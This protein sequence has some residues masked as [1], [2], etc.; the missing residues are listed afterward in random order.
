MDSYVRDCLEI[1]AAL[2]STQIPP[3]RTEIPSALGVY[4]EEGWKALDETRQQSLTEFASTIAS[5]L[6][7]DSQV[8]AMQLLDDLP[9]L[10]NAALRSPLPN[11]YVL[12]HH[13][14]R[15]ANIAWH[16]DHGARL[17]DWSWADIGRPGSDAT[18]LLID[19]HKH[20][21]DITPYLAKVNRE[22]CVAL[23]G[24]WLEHALRPVGE[25]DPSIR[26]HQYVSALAA[27]EVLGACGSGV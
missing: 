2:E 6:R 8:A 18:M 22:H 13:D 16:A 25:R 15:Q 19:L 26:L 24:F 14:A 9:I 20:G 1:F 7:P 3:D 4:W 10:R 17:V 27:Y 12:C 21:H 11:S 23:I 5:R